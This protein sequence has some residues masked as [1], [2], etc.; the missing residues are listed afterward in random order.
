MAI[1]HKRFGGGGGGKT[2]TREGLFPISPGCG[3]PFSA[4]PTA[5]MRENKNTF[6]LYLN[7]VYTKHFGLPSVFLRKISINYLRTPQRQKN[8][9]HTRRHGAGRRWI[10]V[11]LTCR[12]IP[13]PLPQCGQRTGQ[14]VLVPMSCY[15]LSARKGGTMSHH[16]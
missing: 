14:T 2:R 6:L 16:C 15:T 10:W 8:R 4:H 3:V 5:K 7:L 11:G 13:L 9:H 1:L 12:R